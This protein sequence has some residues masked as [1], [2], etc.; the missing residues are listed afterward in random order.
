MR[1]GVESLRTKYQGNNVIE[2]KK[3]QCIKDNNNGEDKE[4]D[5]GED[6]ANDGNDGEDKEEDTDKDEGAKEDNDDDNDDNTNKDEDKANDNGE[7]DDEDKGT[8]EDDND[9]NGANEDKDDNADADKDDNDD[10]DCYVLTLPLLFLLLCPIPILPPRSGIRPHLPPLLYLSSP[11]LFLLTQSTSFP[12]LAP[13]PFNLGS[14]MQ[15]WPYNM[16]HFATFHPYHTD[17]DDRKLCLTAYLYITHTH[18]L[19]HETFCLK[20]VCPTHY[21]YSNNRHAK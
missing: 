6:I 12:H 11:M 13:K 17:T 15:P 8:E 19:K 16:H 7:D 5:I 9:D 20:C 1:Q 3:S 21:P 14:P 10:A 4:E 2:K 18:T